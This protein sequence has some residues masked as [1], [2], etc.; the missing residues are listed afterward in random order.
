MKVTAKNN[1]PESEPQMT[2]LNEGCSDFVELAAC[3][4]MSSMLEASVTSKLELIHAHIAMV[5]GLE[6][7]R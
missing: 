1:K 6:R 4:M 2:A 3:W 5:T 7:M